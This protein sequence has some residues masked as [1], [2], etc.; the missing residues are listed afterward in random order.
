MDMEGTSP[1]TNLNQE[2]EGQ[3][4]ATT[5]YFQKAGTSNPNFKRRFKYSEFSSRLGD[6]MESRAHRVFEEMEK[7]LKE[8]L[9]RNT[10]LVSNEGISEAVEKMSSK[11]KY[12]TRLT[13]ERL[14]LYFI[15][16]LKIKNRKGVV[17]KIK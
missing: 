8:K 17:T 6:R 2:G 5:E 10:S 11:S 15:R 4:G 7:E 12:Q 14:E 1:F 3:G 16:N 9:R 13:L